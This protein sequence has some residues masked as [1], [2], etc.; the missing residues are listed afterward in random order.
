MRI[1]AAVGGNALLRRGQPLTSAS[2]VANLHVASESL[3]ALIRTGNNVIVSHGNGPQIGL[4]ALQNEAIPQSEFPLDVLGA[5]SQGMIGYQLQ[6]A[7]DGALGGEHVFATVLTRILVDPHD[8]AWASPSKPIGPAYDRETAER[9]AK[10]RN[11]KIAPDGPYWRR[12]V[13]SPEPLELLEARAIG[14]LAGAGVTVICAGGGGIPVA[15]TPEGRLYGVEAVVDKDLASALLARQLRADFLLLLTDVDA[16][17]EGWG[18]SEKTPI[19]KITAR[20]LRRR[21]FEAGSMQPKVDAA[22]DFVNTTGKKAGIGAL[23][24]AEK[25]LAEVA[26]T[27]VTA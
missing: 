19:R 6:M 10:E 8:E 26:G 22:M 21:K 13:A 23:S 25:I 4:L 12:V 17:Y 15:E 20:E 18:T 2:Q 11:W 5:E 9:L 24:D 16:V 1:V 7:L 27:L 14:M 3:A